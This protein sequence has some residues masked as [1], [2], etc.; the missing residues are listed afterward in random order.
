MV[1][2]R[3][4][5]GVWFETG[6]GNEREIHYP[7]GSLMD[8]FVAPTAPGLLL[9]HGAGN[10]FVRHLAPGERILVKPTALLFKDVSVSMQLHLEKPAGTWRSWRSWGDRYVW[11]RLHGPGRVAVQSAFEPLEDDGRSIVN[12]SNA[13]FR[14]W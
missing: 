8:R 2:T 12:H 14:N 10:V 3:F 6:A 5:S 4:Q 7:L 11:L 9:L 1:S 13:T